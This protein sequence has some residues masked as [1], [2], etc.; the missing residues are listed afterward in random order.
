MQII[1]GVILSVLG[2]CVI[3]AGLIMA[4]AMGRKSGGFDLE[5]YGAKEGQ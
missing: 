3:A 2:A 5:G 4:G 1:I